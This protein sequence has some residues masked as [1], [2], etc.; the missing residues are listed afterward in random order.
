MSITHKKNPKPLLNLLINDISA[1]SASQISSIKG[2]C[3]F[4]IFS[5]KGECTFVLF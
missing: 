2:E 3:T 5:I 1:K 4:Q